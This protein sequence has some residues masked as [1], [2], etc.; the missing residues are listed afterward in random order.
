MTRATKLLF[1][2]LA[3]LLVAAGLYATTS[4]A[5]AVA[6]GGYSDWRTISAGGSQTCGIRATSQLYCWG[7]DG[8]GSAL[9]PLS[10]YRDWKSV[11]V[12]EAHRCAIRGSGSLY[13]WGSDAS[14]Q[15]GNGATGG[16][17][18]PGP[19]Q[20]TFRLGCSC[21]PTQVVSGSD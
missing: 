11:S 13:C 14:G 2:V 5:S 10:G 12:G 6:Y 7:T 8:T 1:A 19:V 18:T 17:S 21:V 9:Y 16:P 15:V 4:P 3:P 20:T